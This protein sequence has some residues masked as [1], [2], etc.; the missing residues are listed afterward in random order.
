MT[1]EPKSPPPPA[2]LGHDDAALHDQVGRLSSQVTEL[3]EEVAR[4][5]ERTVSSTLL[6]TLASRDYELLRDIPVTVERDD[7]ETCIS[8]FEVGVTGVADTWVGALMSFEDRLLR[9][10]TDL[11]AKPDSELGPL[12]S[13]WKRTLATAIR[14]A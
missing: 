5:S 4:L 13:R 11:D 10:F 14:R 12:P 2:A 7:E 6:T 3:R 8:W 9:L 1:T